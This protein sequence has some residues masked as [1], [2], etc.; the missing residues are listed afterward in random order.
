MQTSTLIDFLAAPRIAYFSMEMALAPDMP[1]YSGGLGVL[2]GDTMRSAADL[3]LPMVGVTLTSRGGYFRQEIDQQGRQVEYEDRWNP[4]ERARALP[5]KVAIEIEGRKVWIVAW[6]HVVPGHTGARIPVLM[7]DT[8]LPENGE[9]DRHITDHLYGGDN[10][11][12]LKQEVVLGIGGGR[13]LAAL[14]FRIRRYHLN[15]GHAALLCLTLLRRTRTKSRPGPHA[16]SLHYNIGE[17]RSLCVFTTHTPVEAGHDRFP[18]PLVERILGTQVDLEL[19]RELAGESQMNMTTLALNLSDY[20]NG[21]AR[22]HAEQSRRMFPGYQVHA[23]TNGV[24]PFT[25]T[26]TSF[27]RL[28]N[29]HFPS[30]CNEPETLA[31]ATTLDDGAIELAHREARLALL[32]F[33]F[34]R[35]GV[36]LREDVFTLCF[37][38]RMTGYKRPGLLFSDLE[39]LRCIARGCPIQIIV[40]GK[41]HPNDN[42]GK[43]AIEQVN[44]HLKALAPEVPGAYVPGYAMDSARLLVSGAD[45]WLNNPLPPL[46]ASGT[47]G[48]K[49]AFNGVPSLSVLDGWWLEGCFEGVTGWSIGAQG[50]DPDTHAQALYEKLEHVVLPLFSNDRPGWTAVM[51][52]AIAQNATIFT[53]HRMMRR[54]ASEAYLSPMP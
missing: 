8:D 40:A 47:S 16:R 11:Y 7:L 13:M 54:Y 34:E 4:A 19:L 3:E 12:R 42:E 53:T 43:R 36:R 50:D 29:H 49:A 26:C 22:S 27:A 5:A 41:A 35:C 37:A 30:W 25:W 52:G 23:I 10:A 48:M 46:E 39:R 1:T 2:A 45:V 9:E 28:Y 20:V 15:E 14:G 51:K 21:V 24:H 38:R 31:R 18:Y 44:A 33:I 6:L 17:V 32:S